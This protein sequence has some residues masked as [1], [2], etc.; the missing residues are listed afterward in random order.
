MYNKIVNPK[1]NRKVNINTNLGKN[2]LKNY[3]SK[4]S[5]GGAV[6]KDKE[7]ENTKHNKCEKIKLKDKSKPIVAEKKKISPKTAKVLERMAEIPEDD[8]IVRSASG[9]KETILIDDDSPKLIYD[10]YSEMGFKRK[11]SNKTPSANLYDEGILVKDLIKNAKEREKERKNFSEKDITM[12]SRPSSNIFLLEN[13][14]NV[15]ESITITERGD[16]PGDIE[17]KTF[18]E[19]Q[20]IKISLRK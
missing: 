18:K 2:I 6:S 14:P 3:L 17:L 7:S 12:Y 4:L 15:E 10:P 11:G 9:K 1:T 5:R 16:S 20:K 19:D 8:T 13:T